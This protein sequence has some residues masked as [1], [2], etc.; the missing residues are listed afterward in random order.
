MNTSTICKVIEHI[1][2]SQIINY[3]EKHN[4][5]F[6]HQHGFRKGY[7][8]DTQ[9]AGFIHEIHS[10]VDAG[11]KVDAIF[12][13]FSKAFDRVPH[14]RLIHKLTLLNIDS[15][16]ITWI[17][18]F[19]S[20]RMQFTSVN[21]RNSSLVPVTSGARQGSVLGPLLFLVYI[22]GILKHFLQ[23]KSF[24]SHFIIFHTANSKI[25]SKLGINY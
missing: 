4:L 8:C 19:L 25:K 7:S 22:K 9:L 17:K 6:R 18:D 14:H 5:I 24:C 20:N 12:L 1:I 3:L 11:I 13:D 10:S 2:H 15:A 16:V 23:K 21:N